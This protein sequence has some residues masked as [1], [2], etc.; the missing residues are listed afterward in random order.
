MGDRVLVNDEQRIVALRWSDGTPVWGKNATIYKN[1][2]LGESDA[3]IWT[4]PRH[5]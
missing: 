4:P 5:C 3:P 1:E 2:N